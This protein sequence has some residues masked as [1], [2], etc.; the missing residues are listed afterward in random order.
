[1]TALI[2]GLVL[3][4]LAVVPTAQAAE[5]AATCQGQ[6]ATIEGT[7]E[8]GGYGT[9]GDDVI[10]VT[11]DGSRPIAVRGG[12]GDDL[13]CIIGHLPDARGPEDD[14]SDIEGGEGTDSLQYL[15]SDQDDWIE[16]F[17][18]ETLD[19]RTAGGRDRIKL[20][21]TLTGGG[22]VRA[23]GSKNNLY[24]ARTEDVVVDLEDHLLEVGGGG[25]HTIVGFERVV[26]S[27]P[28]VM[29]TG[30]QAVEPARGVRLLGHPARRQEAHLL[31][32]RFDRHA[33]CRKPG[34]KISG[35]RGDDR[36]GGT[37]RGDVL[38]GGPGRDR[39]DGRGGEDK[40]SAEREQ[41]CER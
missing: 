10:V 34:A 23:G 39:A 18:V 15:G 31:R 13:I 25:S 40:C 26:A 8:T 38:V 21:G 33:T 9:D 37:S 17:D 7:Q 22:V 29:L 24:L 11:V 3:A 36:L 27:A 5:A 2:A 12:A 6:P 19:I 28:D 14:E 35:H 4:G 1:M 32:A 41:S 16:V 20:F 30:R